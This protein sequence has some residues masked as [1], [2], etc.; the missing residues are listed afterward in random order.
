MGG[1]LLTGASGD[2]C[3]SMFAAPTR[4]LGP[5]MCASVRPVVAEI[6]RQHERAIEERLHVRIVGHG[7]D[8]QVHR[9]RHID[10]IA[11]PPT[12]RMAR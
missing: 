3:C 12:R 4:R 2:P 11:R 1:V 9:E 5:K 7:F 6:A 8:V 10:A